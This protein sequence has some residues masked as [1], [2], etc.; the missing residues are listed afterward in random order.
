MKL[1]QRI[2]ALRNKKGLTQEQVAEALGV[3]RARY[4]AWE[5]SISNPDIEMLDKLAAFHKI[6]V[7]FL[8]GRPH[9]ESVLTLPSEMY[10]DGYTDESVYDEL[11]EDL[12]KRIPKSVSEGVIKELV[13]KYNIDLTDPKK[14]DMLEKMIRIVAED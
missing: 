3:K 13:E 12:Q 5:Q 9:Q 11:E 4:N 8:L 2:A 1:G 7:D 10:A 6:T 14:K